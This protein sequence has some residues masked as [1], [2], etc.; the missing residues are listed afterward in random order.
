MPCYVLCKIS[1]KIQPIWL[2]F[3]ALSRWNDSM[4]ITQVALTFSNLVFKVGVENIKT[5]FHSTYQTQKCVI[6][7]NNI[8]LTNISCL[9]SVRGRR[10]LV[11]LKLFIITSVLKSCWL[12]CRRANIAKYISS[13]MDRTYFWICE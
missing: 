4:L 8:I 9:Q 5:C 12:Q 6:W 13:S 10:C 2:Q 7:L 11:T 1:Q 3:F